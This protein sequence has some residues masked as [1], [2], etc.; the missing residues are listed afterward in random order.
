MGFSYSD[1]LIVIL[2]L[3]KDLKVQ[4]PV[5]LSTQDTSVVK[6]WAKIY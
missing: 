3:T 6:E 4:L 2:L 1:M 5:F